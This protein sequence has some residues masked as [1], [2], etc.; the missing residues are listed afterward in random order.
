[1]INIPSGSAR[2]CL[3]PVAAGIIAYCLFDYDTANERPDDKFPYPAGRRRLSPLALE[4]KQRVELAR[5]R[6]A[7]SVNRELVTLYWQI[8]SD[9]LERQ[10]RQGWG[11]KSSIGWRRT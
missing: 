3:I 9:I 8:G 10:E 2:H 11:Q 7:A 5:A 4:L 1:L 6:A